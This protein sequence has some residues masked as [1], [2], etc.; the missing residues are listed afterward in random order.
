MELI[1]VWIEEVYLDDVNDVN[2]FFVCE[3]IVLDIYCFD[4]ENSDYVEG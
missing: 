4:V 1:M 3:F 2:L